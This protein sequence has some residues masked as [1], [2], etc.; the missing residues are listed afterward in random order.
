MKYS[1]SIPL[2]RT[3]GA[4]PASGADYRWHSRRVLFVYYLR[5]LSH[6]R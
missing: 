2:W 3:N 4:P 1:D 6:E 5:L